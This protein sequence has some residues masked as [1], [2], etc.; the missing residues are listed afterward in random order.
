MRAKTS[1]NQRATML[2]AAERYA[3]S[4]RSDPFTRNRVLAHIKNGVAS[5]MR[6][7]RVAADDKWNYQDNGKAMTPANAEL[8]A[9][10]DAEQYSEERSYMKSDGTEVRYTVPAYR[11]IVRP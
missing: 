2:Q 10:Y 3:A 9:Y 7:S 6:G 4:D 1:D 5:P 8:D 11:N